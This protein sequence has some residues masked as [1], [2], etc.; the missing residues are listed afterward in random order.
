MLEALGK[1]PG[2]L[3]WW[4]GRGAAKASLRVPP[5]SHV[6]CKPTCWSCRRALRPD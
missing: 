2:A 6:R 1:Y 5:A 4:Q 3:C